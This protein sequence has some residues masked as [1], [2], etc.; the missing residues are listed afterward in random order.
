[1]DTKQLETLID[2]W[3]TGWSQS[4]GFE[5][6]RDGRAFVIS[7]PDGTIDKMLVSATSE[8]IAQHTAADDG[9][10]RLLLI[11]EK[12]PA[13]L[14]AASGAGLSEPVRTE[15]LM[16]TE[17]QE[18]DV[19]APRPPGDDIEPAFDKPEDGVTVVTVSVK[20]VPAA[21]GTVSVVNSVAIF[22]RIETEPEYRRRGLASY[23]MQLL[24][25]A[26]L[27]EDVETGLLAASPDGRLLYNHL[28]WREVADMPVF[29]RAQA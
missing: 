29:E 25:H 22:D 26:A 16:V 12:L 17:I 4:R 19:E 3:M 8:E 9:C 14:E 10:T 20:G 11:T 13:T 27:N 23:V 15:T 18:Y 24:T 1:M 21:S 5:P 7:R 2:T 28:G 6:K